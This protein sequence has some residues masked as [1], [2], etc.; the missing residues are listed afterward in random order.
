MYELKKMERYCWDR[1][2]VLRKKNLPGRGLKKAE[3][4]RLRTHTH[5]HTH[6][7]TKSI[8][9]LFIFAQQQWLRESPCAR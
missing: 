1:A 3:K 2:L 4:H 8:Q 7:H 6:T 9:F 5:A